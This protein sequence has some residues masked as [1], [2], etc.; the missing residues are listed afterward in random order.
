MLRA[1]LADAATWQLAHPAVAVSVNVSARQIVDPAFGSEVSA[2]LAQAGVPPD[3]LVLELTE[4]A[5]VTHVD[6]ALAGVREL[7]GLGARL[8]VDD[9]GTGYSSLSQ[10]R[11]FPVDLL[12]IDGSFVRSMST[13]PRDEALVRAVLGLGRSLQIPT[14]A[15]GIETTAQLETLRAND[16]DLGQGFLLGR[17][18]P[19][20]EL[21]GY[22]AKGVVVE[23]SVAA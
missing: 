15:E 4:T 20:G 23:P 11:R 7:K 14:V 3:R 13:E 16:C 19:A 2:L 17:P 12:K 1:A 21:A 18:M 8:A 6:A 9:F 5:L 10:L 22:L